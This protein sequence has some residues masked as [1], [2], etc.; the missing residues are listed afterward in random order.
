MPLQ[1]LIPLF[2]GEETVLPMPFHQPP[3]VLIVKVLLPVKLIKRWAFN[4]GKNICR[5][6]VKEKDSK[7]ALWEDRLFGRYLLEMS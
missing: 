2:R 6:L 5:I 3:S 4:R 1:F 7:S